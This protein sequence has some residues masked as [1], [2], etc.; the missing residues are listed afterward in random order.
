MCIFKNKNSKKM[1][2]LEMLALTPI[3]IILT[4]RQQKL[5]VKYCFVIESEL[6]YGL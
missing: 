2:L 5:N 3:I 4:T 6:M 1:S